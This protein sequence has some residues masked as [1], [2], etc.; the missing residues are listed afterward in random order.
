MHC[1]QSFIR[2]LIGTWSALVWLL[3]GTLAADAKN[4]GLAI[5]IDA[6]D[7]WRP[8]DK[9]VNDAEAVAATLRELGFEANAKVNV[10]RDEFY[11]AWQ[12]FLNQL[13]EGDVAAL[14]FAGHG[15]EIASANYLMPRDAPKVQLGS[16][17]LL[18]SGAIRFSDLV[19]ELQKKKVAALFIIDACRNNPFPDPGRRGDRGDDYTRA[20]M[21]VERVEGA[22]IM[23]SA[24]TGQKA[25]DR[26]SSA[27]IDPNSPFTRSLLPILKTPGLSLPQIAVRARKEVIALA[28]Q[29]KPPHEQRPAYYDELDGEILLKPASA[30]SLPPVAPPPPS[31]EFKKATAAEEAKEKEELESIELVRKLRQEEKKLTAQIEEL[32]AINAKIKSEA[33]LED[34]KRE[35]KRLEDDIRR[36]Q[37][38]WTRINRLRHH[39]GRRPLNTQVRN[40]K[41][42]WASRTGSSLC[43]P[44]PV[45]RRDLLRSCGRARGG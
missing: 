34:L 25:L 38:E 44:I 18:A 3:T 26:L 23:Y 2:L 24:G 8:L 40:S 45:G 32:R 19:Y 20:L 11:L 10:T 6:Y 37:E 30:G 35:R 43:A 12:T 39:H 15:I 16:Q 21:R 28:L 5:G 9:A 33:Q 42:R 29:A 13:K 1:S 41:S 22:F 17:S 31:A 27:D 7:N 36:K 4:V 14:F